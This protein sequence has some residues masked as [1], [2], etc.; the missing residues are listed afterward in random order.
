M[1]PPKFLIVASLI[2]NAILVPTAIYLEFQEANASPVRLNS[3][4][5]TFACSVMGNIR[6]V[7]FG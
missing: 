4:N 7:H 1:N 3:A 2:A 6:T 5:S